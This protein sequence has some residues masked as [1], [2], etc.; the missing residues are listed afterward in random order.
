MLLAKDDLSIRPVHRPPRPDAA[1]EGPPRS[2]AQIWMAAA[3]FFEDGDRSQS[4]RCLQHRDDFIVPNIG[5]RIGAPSFSAR[6]LLAGKPGIRLEPV[7]G[8]RAESGLR[9]GNRRRMVATQVHE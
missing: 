4:G 5:E 2:G 9:A 1:L 3:E 8:C 7:A 6:L